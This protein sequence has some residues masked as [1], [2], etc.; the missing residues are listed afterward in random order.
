MKLRDLCWLGLSLVF[1]HL[2]TLAH[3]SMSIYDTNQQVTVEGTLTRIQW[4]NP[5]VYF[6]V[7]ETL[8]S[9]ELVRW[10]VEGLGPASYRRIGWARDTVKVGDSM[11]IVGNPTRN[12]DRR[13]IYPVSIHHEQDKLFDSMEF[14]NVALS[15]ADAAG[16]STAGLQGK[17]MTQLKFELILQFTESIET[18]NLTEAGKRALAEFEEATMNPAANCELIVAPLFMIMPDMKRFTISEDSV[19][20]QGDYDG[21][22]RIIHLDQDSHAA[23][24]VSWQGHSIGRWQGSTLEIDTFKF[25]ENSMGNGWGIPSSPQKRMKETITLNADGSSFNYEF[26]LTDPVYLSAP[27]AGMTDFKSSPNLDFNI[28]E[29]DLESART[30]IGN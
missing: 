8:D 20:I 10:E 12:I 24:P 7:E 18:T 27:F 13:G 15:A 19:R 26:E 23:A 21:A 29:C 28:H 25:A 17:W 16:T 3:H 30:Y 4:T 2:S 22:E 6:Y 1:F 5:H 9:G 14:M 11:T